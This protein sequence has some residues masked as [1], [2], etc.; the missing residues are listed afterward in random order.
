MKDKVLKTDEGA[1]SKAR[2]RRS[3]SSQA[4]RAVAANQRR[5]VW[6]ARR[7]SGGKSPCT[8][9]AQSVGTSLIVVPVN[10]QCYYTIEDNESSRLREGRREGDSTEIGRP[11]AS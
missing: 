3:R 7:A 5:S 10:H 2:G 4:G 6:A 1:L 11:K 8:A 9:G